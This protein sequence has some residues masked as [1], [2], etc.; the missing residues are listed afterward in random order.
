MKVGLFGINMGRCANRGSIGRIAR[1]AEDVG[2][3]SL[4]VG[5]HVVLPDPQA[6]PSPVPPGL[7]MLDPVV[8]L[9]YAAAHTKTIRLATGIIILPQRNPL[10]LAKELASLDVLSGG[11]LIVG[12]GIGYLKAEFA[13]LGIPFSDKGARTEE[14]LA[15][16][17]AVWSQEKPAFE[18]DTVRFSGIDAHP[19]PTQKPWP[20][21]VFGGHSPAAYGRAARLASGWY[22]FHLDPEAAKSC[23]EGVRAACREA[24]RSEPIEIS[25][26]P[27]AKFPVEEI[28][29]YAEAG[30]DRVVPMAVAEEID[31]LRMLE[32]IAMR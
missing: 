21:I 28:E 2:A 27:P 16:M 11:R 1:A 19:R 26:T 30:V 25:V 4:W 31:V 10:V 7:P 24:G 14:Y 9:T 23:V 17:K 12:L 20:P 22:G 18:G 8:A 29:A 32:R 6:P 3:D 15:A 5:E 13:A